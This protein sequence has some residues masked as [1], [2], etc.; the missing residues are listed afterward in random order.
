VHALANIIFAQSTVGECITLHDSVY[1]QLVYVNGTALSDT[2][3]RRP[4]TK[5]FIHDQ[6]L[7]AQVMEWSVLK[8]TAASVGPGVDSGLGG[9]QQFASAHRIIVLDLQKRVLLN[10]KK[11]GMVG[12][13]I[14]VRHC[15]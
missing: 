14:Y 7:T 5:T 12:L 3:E 6:P 9:S 4:K 8:R 15:R 2:E 11:D 13:L 1:E 10:K